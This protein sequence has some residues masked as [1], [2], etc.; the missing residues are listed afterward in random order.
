MPHARSE[1]AAEA[2]VV[3]ADGFI[4]THLVRT[5]RT[6]GVPTAAFTRTRP[7]AV[8]G[9]PHPDLCSARTVY[10]LAT[11]V[12]IGMAEHRPDLLAA[13]RALF[14]TFQ[15]TVAAAGHRPVVV[16]TS[17]GGAVYDPAVPPPYREESPV[18]P[19]T[20]YGRGKAAMEAEVIGCGDTLR[21]V[22]TRLSNPY[23]PGQ[24]LGT[25][26]G[27]IAHWLD[28]ALRGEPLRLFGNP[29]ATRDYVY[30]DDAIEALV[31]IH[32]RTAQASLPVVLNIGSGQ[33]TALTEL[34]D[35][36][37]EVAAELRPVVELATERY[38]DRRDTW[39]DVSAAQQALD[40]VATASL[41]SGIGRTWQHVR[42]GVTPA[43]TNLPPSAL[44]PSAIEE[45]TWS[46]QP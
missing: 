40:W 16:L 37:C 1:T 27:V 26:Q 35:I 39:L 38:Y 36:V 19:V 20:A 11:S 23:G 6:A 9:R 42:A 22:I 34:V 25:G 8:G 15:R 17:S 41:H 10:F 12:N 13:D 5:L 14:A 43:V 4:G 21:P 32:H 29:L 33:P 28:A 44:P 18:R 30:I 7:F 31:R 46:R 3:G 45:R 24:R 2:A